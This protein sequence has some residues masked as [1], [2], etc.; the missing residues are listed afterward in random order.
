NTPTINSAA[1]YQA[2]ANTDEGKDAGLKTGGSS[3]SSGMS[4][5]E[6]S[7]NSPSEKEEPGP[8]PPKSTP[9]PPSG[10]LGNNSGDLTNDDPS[11]PP[12]MATTPGNQKL[13]PQQEMDLRDELKELERNGKQR[14]PRAKEIKQ[15]L[16]K[17][18]K[19]MGDR[20]SRQKKDRIKKIVD[21]AVKTGVATGAG[22]GLAKVADVIEKKMGALSGVILLIPE[23]MLE[24]VLKESGLIGNDFE[25][26]IN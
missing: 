22:A 21:A 3:S 23:P 14:S 25:Q 8:T 19:A 20:G 7:G 24:Y 11:I 16:K 18:E 12:T 9:V 2:Y 1:D 17:H 5:T 6:G 4:G 26:E 10:D 13:D 15:K